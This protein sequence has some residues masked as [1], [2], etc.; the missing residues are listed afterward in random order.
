MIKPDEIIQFIK[1][2][3]KATTQDIVKR[4]G[5]SRQYA[6]LLVRQLVKSG[7]LVKFGS[8]RSSFY[9]CPDAT[10]IIEG[11][12]KIRARLKN[13]NLKEHIVYER[14]K[15]QNPLI[16]SL[17]ENI[18]SIFDFAFTEMLN[19]A[20][21]HSKSKYIEI[22]IGQKGKNIEFHVDDFGIGVFRNV[23]KKRN[24][25]SELEAIQDLLKGKTTTQPKSHTG[26]GIFFTSKAA[27]IFQLESYGYKLTVNNLLPDIFIED[28]PKKAKGT[29]VTFVI[30]SDSP[31]HLQDVFRKYYTEPEN[32][33]FDKTEIHVKL[34]TMGTIHISR[35]QAKRVLVGLEK[36]KLVILDF[37]GVP[38][39]GQ[40]FADEVFRV[41]KEK[42]PD[43]EIK[44]IN[45]NETVQFM[46]E[47]A[48]NT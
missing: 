31:R 15:H 26:E 42:H 5:V 13:A 45:M 21:E 27:D 43:I 36:F 9:V 7:R 16:P 19:N 28:L 34:Y 8:T 2:R 46:V 1:K 48:K 11:N 14:L 23:M 40:A 6:N 30:Q 24:L 29:K 17:S 25:H 18:K 47:R 12:K 44:P 38:T 41:F 35:S 37:D 20:M 33:A 22:E 3:G 4:F 39:V 10:E 32:Y